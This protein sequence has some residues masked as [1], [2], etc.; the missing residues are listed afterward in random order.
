MATTR[1]QDFKRWLDADEAAAVF[2]VAAQTLRLWTRNKCFPQPHTFGPRCV[3]WWA[4]AVDWMATYCPQGKCSKVKMANLA[5][6]LDIEAGISEQ[7]RKD[8]AEAEANGITQS[9]SRRFLPMGHTGRR[10]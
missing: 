9:R 8:I 2:G 6:R 1:K 10:K 5:R 4:P 7:R 3:R